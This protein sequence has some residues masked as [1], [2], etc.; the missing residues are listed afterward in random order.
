MGD[1]TRIYPSYRTQ[2]SVLGRNTLVDEDISSPVS[3][4]CSSCFVPSCASLVLVAQFQRRST[5]RWP[6]GLRRQTK[7]L[8]RKGASSNLALVKYF[9]SS[10]SWSGTMDFSLSDFDGSILCF[11][12]FFCCKQACTLDLCV[13]LR[14]VDMCITSWNPT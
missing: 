13:L 7:D 1:D 12:L 5:A 3:L 4:C 10:P 2:Q 14:H 11:W 8:V 9:S 6:S